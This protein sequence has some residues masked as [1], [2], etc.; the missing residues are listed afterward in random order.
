MRGA[1]QHPPVGCADK[2]LAGE[3]EALL[4]ADPVAQRGEVAVLEGRHPQL[5]LVQPVRP[6]T[7]RASL[8][9]DDQLGARERESAH[10]L[11]VVTVVTDGD[12]D[13]AG[14]GVEDRRPGVTRRVV[15]LLVK[16]RVVGD[17]NHA[18]AAKAN[19]ITV[20]HR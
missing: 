2:G 20:D 5:R 10:V 16:A 17:V 7:D 18:R 13:P 1:R 12:A 15:A 11:R 3:V 9:H 8:R 6:L 19:A 14:G 4:G